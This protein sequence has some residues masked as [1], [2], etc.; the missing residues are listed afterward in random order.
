MDATKP[1]IDKATVGADNKSVRLHV[2]QLQEGHIHHLVAAG[3]RST[4]GALLLH[5]AAYYTLNYIPEK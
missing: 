4:E 3:V 5:N 1:V 2:S